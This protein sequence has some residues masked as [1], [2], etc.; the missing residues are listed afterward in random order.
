MIKVEGRIS[1][2]LWQHPTVHVDDHEGW[3]ADASIP[4]VRPE[5]SYGR[6]HHRVIC[7]LYFPGP[8]GRA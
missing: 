5:R 8:A 4:K 3:F 1:G 2:L 7:G 6:S